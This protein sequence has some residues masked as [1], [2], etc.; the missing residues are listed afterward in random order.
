VSAAGHAV[1]QIGDLSR[2]P[3]V[4]RAHVRWARLW[5]PRRCLNHTLNPKP[6]TLNPKPTLTPTQMH[7]RGH[8]HINL[9]EDSATHADIRAALRAP[10]HRVSL[11]LCVGIYISVY[12]KIV[13]HMRISER[14]FELPI[15]EECRS[16]FREF[17]CRRNFPVCVC[18]CVRARVRV[19][20]VCVCDIYLS[21]YT[22]T[23]TH[24]Y[25]YMYIYICI[26]VYIYTYNR[27]A[28]TGD[29]YIYIYI[30][31]HTYV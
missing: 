15:I 14:H 3:P 23:H 22:H 9:Q 21:L 4:C 12:K 28:V 29:I 26:C 7:L 31:I 17:L 10:Y 18:L 19:Y 25:T 13:P 2:I 20:Y 16:N 8:I 1:L 30:H 27:G 5:L 24:T 11:S 6:Y